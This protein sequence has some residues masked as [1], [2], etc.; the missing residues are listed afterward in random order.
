[1]DSDLRPELQWQVQRLL[2]RCLLR[3]QQYEHLMKAVLAH[4]ELAGP[5][6]ELEALREERAKTFSRKSLGQLAGALFETYVVVEDTAHSVLDESKAPID[7]IS[8]GLQVRMETSVEGWEQTR[9][10]VNDLVA[11]RNDLV[12]HFIEQ[13]DLWTEAGCLAVSEHLTQCFE[14]IESYFQQ[15][16]NWAR[17]VDEARALTLSFVQSDAFRELMVNGI[18]PDGS[19]DW[20]DTGI[21]R[22]LREATQACGVD[23]WVRLD[24]AKAW[25]GQHCNEQTPERYGCRSWPQVLHESRLFR[26][27]YR[28]DTEGRKVA[29]FRER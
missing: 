3:L 10:A 17:Y 5:V 13:F 25:I 2:G 9:S 4:H 28:P 11:M 16:Q 21:V 26:L 14:R 27:E 29:W 24:A 15:L 8:M 12:H 6:D 1:M 20:P 23:G 19:F 22:A 7:K 18:A